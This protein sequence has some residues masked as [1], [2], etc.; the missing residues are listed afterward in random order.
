MKLALAMTL[1]AAA[2]GQEPQRIEFHQCPG[3]VVTFGIVDVAFHPEAQKAL[4]L[5]D[6]SLVRLALLRKLI[7]ER[8]V[9][10]LGDAL[11]T[12]RPTF[13][14]LDEDL[15]AFLRKYPALAAAVARNYEPLDGGRTAI[16]V[17]RPR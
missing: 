2:F 4:Q 12:A 17:R 5:S 7:E 14:S 1:T 13:V 15:Q 9:A 11:L 10:E 6:E 3:V 8:G 16:A